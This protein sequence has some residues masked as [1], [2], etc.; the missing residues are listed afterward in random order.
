MRLS[1][2]GRIIKQGSQVIRSSAL[3]RS[4]AHSPV[5]PYGGSRKD[6]EA[7]AAAAADAMDDYDLLEW[8][9]GVLGR[10]NF[11]CF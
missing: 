9:A 4:I 8:K 1:I 2:D 5:C 11:P 10:G 3:R 6:D 7:A